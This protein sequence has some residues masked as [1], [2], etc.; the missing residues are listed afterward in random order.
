MSPC[1]QNKIVITAVAA[2]LLLQKYAAANIVFQEQGDNAR[3]WSTNGGIT[4]ILS[5]SP[6][7]I[8][9]FL[10]EIFTVST[11][12]WSDGDQIVEKKEGS[13]EGSMDSKRVQHLWQRRAKDA[14]YESTSLRSLQSSSDPSIHINYNITLVEFVEECKQNL[15]SDQI[16]ADNLISQVDIIGFIS[17]Y[18]VSFG[19]C[20]KSNK[21]LDFH[22]LDLVFQLHFI[23]ALCPPGSQNN[24]VCLDSIK[25]K[26]SAGELFGF[27]VTVDNKEKVENDVENYCVNMYPQTEAP[28]DLPSGAP[29]K[30][31][32]TIVPT[33]FPSKQTTTSPTEYPSKQP[34]T[35]APTKTTTAPTKISIRATI[36]SGTH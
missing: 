14:E 21:D 24:T 7:R 18:C 3:H 30:N 36:N 34:T 11:N 32:T 12:F 1:Y 29:S 10:S 28:T 2:L 26:D 20:T 22:E 8:R 17:Q 5:K 6:F 33:K 15:L 19:Y 16:L 4:S 31:P 9:D 25:D 23:W 35:M 13:K 27:E